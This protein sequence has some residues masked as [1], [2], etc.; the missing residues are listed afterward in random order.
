M[1]AC[2]PCLLSTRRPLLL[3]GTTTP[4][5]RRLR[6]RRAC[7]Q[8]LFRCARDYT[9]R[10]IHHRRRLRPVSLRPATATP[11]RHSPSSTTTTS[12]PFRLSARRVQPTTTPFAR[13]RPPPCLH[14]RPVRPD[15]PTLACLH[16]SPTPLSTPPRVLS[17]GLV[18]SGIP[19][20]QS[21]VG[22]TTAH[23]V[24]HFPRPLPPSTR[25]LSGLCRTVWHNRPRYYSLKAKHALAIGWIWLC[26]RLKDQYTPLFAL[27]FPPG[28]THVRFFDWF[29]ERRLSRNWTISPRP[30]LCTFCTPFCTLTFAFAQ[31]R[32][33]LHAIRPRSF[34]KHPPA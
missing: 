19:V 10:N 9:A 28:R 21:S 34:S 16:T 23:P 27:C 15:P 33:T 8:S 2:A 18:I 17:H 32:D 30:S 12:L 13:P 22:N 6:R 24:A 31:P 25:P 7:S 14:F 4:H 3:A 26:D 5:P 29:E 11:S 20:Q 1:R